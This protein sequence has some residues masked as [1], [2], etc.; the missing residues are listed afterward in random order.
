MINKYFDLIKAIRIEKGFSQEE[1]SQKIGISRTSYIS[2]EKGKTELTFSQAVKVAGILGISL[3]EVEGGVRADYE[4]YKQMV[5]AYLRSGKGESVT[6]TKLAKM[7]YLADFAWFYNK[8]ES[9]S[10]MKYR[11]MQ[12]GPVSDMYFR[13]L[14]ELEE[15]G[16]ISI[17]RVDDS[18]LISENRGSKKSPL[19]KLDNEEKELIEDIYIKWKD[20]KT[21]EI[22]DFTHNQL[23][24]RICASDEII[25]YELIT[26][27]D[28][29][30]VY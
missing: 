18:I 2:F 9:M 6:K 30:H 20:K 3:E 4:K 21:R 19:D 14:D 24:Y 13:A 8:L 1:I 23:P 17:S 5:L 16:K 27:E 28:P 22:V 12:Y 7:L 29:D 10:G 11:K 26:Q 15:V 25:P